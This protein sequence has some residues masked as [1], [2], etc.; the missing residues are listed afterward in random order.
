MKI[1]TSDKKILEFLKEGKTVEEI[2]K[3][4]TLSKL[5]VQFSVIRLKREGLFKESQKPSAIVEKKVKGKG[6][7]K[8]EGQG[9]I[10]GYIETNVD[11]LLHII[12]KEKSVGLEAAASRLKVDKKRLEK[13]AE[14]LE[15]HGL[16]DLHYPVMGKVVIRI[17]GYKP[18][19]G[20]KIKGVET[21]EEKIDKLTR[22]HKRSKKKPV[23]LV[24]VVVVVLLMV[25]WLSVRNLLPFDVGNPYSSLTAIIAPIMNPINDAMGGGLDT[26]LY[27]PIFLIV[28]I[29]IIAILVILK[30]KL[31]SI[32]IWLWKR[33]KH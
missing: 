4:L 32:K 26:Q 21:T 7:E 24:I 25:Y 3:K 8:V 29:A 12:E 15:S 6:G 33:R 2:S 16:V 5:D 23:I 31:K 20:K 10:E 13:W 18:K 17:K 22:P 1:T 28:I 11:K 19:R 14:I 9:H 30:F 27:V